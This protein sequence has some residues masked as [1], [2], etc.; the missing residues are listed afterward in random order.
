MAMKRYL[1]VVACLA[2][3]FPCTAQNPEEP[4][5]SDDVILYLRTMHSHDMM[6]KMLQ[7]QT[8]SMQQLFH[9]MILKEKG[10]VPSDFDANLKKRMDDLI[11]NMPMDEM[12]QAIIPAYQKHF[13]HGDI[14]VMNAFYSSP[15]GQKVLE[16]LPAV[17]G[18]SLQSMMPI[19]SKYLSDWKD[20][21][22]KELESSP[23]SV[24]AKPGESPIPEKSNN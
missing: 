24:P 8:Q 16:E 14:E 13:T 15:V 18:E 19:L 5:S 10:A 3:S 20:R 23:N 6:Q 11:R 21:M 12:V 1:L 17:T 7:V 9:D 2:L 4:A 22:K